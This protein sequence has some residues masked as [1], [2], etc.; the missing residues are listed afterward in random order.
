MN[1]CKSVKSKKNINEPCTNKAKT[2]EIF[3]GKHL[4]SKGIILYNPVLQINNNNQLL[5]NDS[6]INNLVSINPIINNIVN[7][8]I[9][10]ISNDAVNIEKNISTDIFEKNNII[11]ILED[12]PTLAEF[13]DK[14]IKIFSKEELFEIISNDLYINI[15]SIRKSLKNCSLNK[16][17]NT[18]L[19]KSNLI[20]DIKKYM[21]RE[22]Y[23]MSNL[24]SIILLQ[25]FFRKI[26]VLRRK[27]CTNDCDML[28]LSSIYDIHSNYFYIFYDKFTNKKFGYDIRNLYAIIISE[29]QTCPYTF[30]SFTGE[31]K[32]DIINYCQMLED[33]GINIGLEKV[34]FNAEQEL[35]MKMKSIFHKIN[36]LDNYT[37][38]LWFKNLNLY[39][40]IDLYIRSEDIWNYRSGMDLEAKKRIVESGCVFNIPLN[41]IKNIKTKS[42]VQHLLLDEFNKI[43]SE[44]VNKD[45][46]KLGA[47]LILTGLVEVSKDAAESL[48]HLVQYNYI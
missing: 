7:D 22:R 27:E 11:D 37:N 28:T 41:I 24:Q 5:T 33:N 21:M 46:K 14:E 25:N 16:I 42:R 48:P 39:Q 47:I 15:S 8:E 10:L 2:N 29:N 20:N 6:S 34:N 18:K 13:N 1:L 44:G 19:S 45:E 3:C 38:Y 9:N 32:D 17:F 35:E 30:R 23:F 26:L 40:C 4:N 12:M 31:E 36:M 43:V